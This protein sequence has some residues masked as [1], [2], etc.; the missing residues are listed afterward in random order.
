M[1]TPDDCNDAEEIAKADAQ[2]QKLLKARGITDLS[3]VAADPWSVV[4]QTPRHL[5]HLDMAAL[6]RECTTRQIWTKL[7][8]TGSMISKHRSW[9]IRC[10]NVGESQSFSLLST[11]Q[12]LPPKG[13]NAPRLIQTFMYLHAQPADNAYAR[14]L[15]F[16]PVVDLNAKKVQRRCNCHNCW[17]YVLTCRALATDYTLLSIFNQGA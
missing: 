14:P 5:W 12:H 6:N 2:V 10:K 3:L 15:D 4:S 8:S 7:Q 13:T 16:V 9:T 17:V 1:L 11:L